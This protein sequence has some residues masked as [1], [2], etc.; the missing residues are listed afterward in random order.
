LNRL[1]TT[2]KQLKDDKG[3][4]ISNVTTSQ[5]YTWDGQLATKKDEKGKKT[6]YSYDAQGRQIKMVDALGKTT[7]KVYDRLGR[8]TV[9]VAPKNYIENTELSAMER[10]VFIYDAVGRVLEQRELYNK[11]IPSKTGTLN[12]VWSEVPVKKYIYDSMGNVIST[13]DALGNIST[14][15]YNLAGIIETETDAETAVNNYAFTVKYD[16]N[17]LGQKVKEAYQGATYTYTYDGMGN[18]LRTE[19][20]GVMKSTSIYDLA[21]REI[22]LTDALGNTTK[23]LWNN[24]DK[25]SKTTTQGDATIGS[26]QTIYQYDKLGN[27]IYSKDS[28]GAINTY[29]Y[30]SFGRNLS[31]TVK[32]ETDDSKIINFTTYDLNGNVLTKTDGNLNTTSYTY[33]ALNRNVTIKNALNQVTTYTYDANGNLI[34]QKDYLGN[35]TKNVYDGIN[36]LVETRDAYNQIIKQLEYNDANTQ[37]AAYDALHIKTEYL[38]DKNLQQTGITDAMGNTTSMVYDLRGNIIEKKDGNGNTTSYQYDAENLLTKV[39]DALGNS[40]TYT[41]NAAGNLLTQTD[42]NGNTTTYQYNSANLVSSKTDP[43]GAA[44]HYTYYANGKLKGKTDRNGIVTSYT[45]DVFG[46]LLKEDAEGQVQSYTYDGNGNMLTMTDKT[47]TTMRTYD[48]LNRN[49]S[50]DVPYIDK[51]VY[52]YDLAAAAGEYSERTT[53]PKGNVSLKTYDKVGRLSKVTVDGKTTQYEYYSNGNR[54]SVKYPD[55]TTETYTYDKVNRVTRLNNA[56]GDGT[57]IS[58]YSYTYDAAGN[59]LT[60][61][62]SKGTTTYIYDKDNRL[63]TVSEPEGKKTSYTYDAAGNRRSEDV[64]ARAVTSSAIYVYDNCN[65][66]VTIMSSDGTDTRYLYDRNGN[67]ISKSIGKI[68]TIDA[69]KLSQEMLPEFDLII[70]KGDVSGTGTELLTIYSYDNY[71]RLTKLKTANKTTAYKYNAQGYR[72]EKKTN[73]KTIRYLYEYDKVVLETDGN[74]NQTAFQVYGTNL[75]YRSAKGDIGSSA[76]S[77]YY[78][79]NA[80]GD[81]TSLLD[82]SGNIAVSYD[83][84]A[85]GNIKGQTGIADNPIRYA[86]YQYDEE[87]GLYYLNARYYDSVTARFVTEDDPKYSNKNDPLSLNLYSYCHNEP[88]M[89]TDPSG[90]RRVDNEYYY[91]ATSS[92]SKK[93]N[94]SATKKTKTPTPTPKPTPKVTPKPTPVPTSTPK[95]TTTKVGSGKDSKADTGNQDKLRTAQKV[96]AYVG[97][98]FIPGVDSAIDFAEM[99]SDLNSINTANNFFEGAQGVLNLIIDTTAFVIPVVDGPINS[100]GKVYDTTKSGLNA[101]DAS[102]RAPKAIESGLKTLSTPS[103]K[104]LRQNMIEAGIDVPNYANAAHHIVA[105]SSPKAAEARAILQKYGVDIN[106]A[107][108]GVFLPTIKDLSEGAYHPSLHTNAYYNEVNKQLLKATSKDDVLSI[109][110][111]IKEQLIDGTF[112]K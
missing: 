100:I 99:V 25:V 97:G 108:N 87:S 9:I 66:L 22:S 28:M 75:L 52:E 27:L 79:Y 85:F 104:V 95:K 94:S 83:Y 74:N 1:L 76:Q 39:T 7:Y 105:G 32:N 12:K 35:L 89:Y 63:C 44:E 56:K 77:Y 11:L 16:Y 81:V 111:D 60:K 19:I 64:V 14:A 90:H 92:V 17:G 8:N 46:R 49:T 47:G 21:G 109:L 71:N 37:I 41:Y 13:A 43:S 30:D 54:K 42:G 50:K 3:T 91:G 15:T 107:N 70:N 65:R 80:H 10:T 33:D 53:D 73:S 68:E 6:Q 72:V 93:S 59:Q 106:D 86:G 110:D 26:L 34:Q 62:D 18:L 112:L 48:A 82:P 45:Y 101:V 84:D 20:D 103:S 5:T 98:S 96:T 31:Q 40:T 36:R 24:L 4:F 23:K 57:V 2:T 88:I 58:S 61:K 55:G 67:L 102:K 69:E 38:Y 51:S 78:L 29:I